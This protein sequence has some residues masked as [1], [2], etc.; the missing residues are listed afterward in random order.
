MSGV[1]GGGGRRCNRQCACGQWRCGGGDLAVH[2]A[3]LLGERQRCNRQ[4]GGGSGGEGAV[5]RTS[6]GLWAMVF[7]TT[8]GCDGPC[9]G[10]KGGGATGGVVGGRH[11][12]AGH[13]KQ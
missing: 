7:G 1:G 9:F 3:V 12:L 6:R 11:V 2:W 10:G 13:N 4:H 8:R 5:Q